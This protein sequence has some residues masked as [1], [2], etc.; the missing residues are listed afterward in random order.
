MLS[1]SKT[2]HFG[3]GTVII[4]SVLQLVKS[5][6]VHMK[7]VIVLETEK[8]KIQRKEFVFDNTKVTDKLQGPDLS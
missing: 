6:K 8:E 3:K 2:A 7:L 1:V 4:F 5:Q